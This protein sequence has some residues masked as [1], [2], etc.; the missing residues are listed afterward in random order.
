MFALEPSPDSSAPT[1]RRPVALASPVTSLQAQLIPPPRP[2]RAW[3]ALTG[4]CAFAAIVPWAC[5]LL[6]LDPGMTAGAE[7]TSDRPPSEVDVA[8]PR[9]GRIPHEALAVP[10][11]RRP[12]PSPEVFELDDGPPMPSDPAELLS[13]PLEPV[14]LPGT[15]E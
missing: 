3:L 6:P 9:V 13:A 14:R 11:R 1:V 12:R 10:P 5:L 2:S 4:V 7:V 15:K 8:A